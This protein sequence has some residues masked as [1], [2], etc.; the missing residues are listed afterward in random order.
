MAG[1]DLSTELRRRAEETAKAIMSAAQAD[2]DQIAAEAD[3][4]IEKRRAEVL[5]SRE[6]EY[7]AKAR[8]DVA[9]ER[10]EAMRATL[11]AKTRVVDRVLQRAKTLLREAARG[12]AYGSTL[13]DEVTEAVAF[14]GV[15][16]ATVHC[17]NDLEPAVRDA[18]RAT[19]GVSIKG[20]DVGSGFVAVSKDGAVRVDG[21]LEARLERLAPA[22]AI[23]IHQRLEE[24]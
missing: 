13:A 17:S 15:E 7:R 6:G 11:L 1:A 4:A 8:A 16:G 21:T 10:H 19:P 9:G 12:N 18:L 24:H 3:R 5:K 23:E 20:M 14:V 22:L 2:A